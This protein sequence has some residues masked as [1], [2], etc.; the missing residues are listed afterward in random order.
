MCA[1]NSLA[2][3]TARPGPAVHLL[4]LE[5]TLHRALDSHSRQCQKQGVGRERAPKGGAASS[6]IPS[7][8]PS[9]Q[10]RH[11][12][13]F[14]GLRESSGECLPLE[15]VLRTSAFTGTRQRVHEGP[16]GQARAFRV[17]LPNRAQSLDAR[18]Q[19]QSAE[20]WNQWLEN[21]ALPHGRHA[22]DAGHIYRDSI[23]GLYECEFSRRLKQCRIAACL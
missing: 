18:I 22:V 1:R 7:Y 11:I 20:S 8:V 21:Y 15:R 4:V 14:S 12:W 2:Q 23:F 13:H 5:P 9:N 16:A 6:S 17:H 19:S 3:G 10:G